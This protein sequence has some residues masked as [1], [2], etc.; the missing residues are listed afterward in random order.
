MNPASDD[1]EVQPLV[2]PSVA[3]SNGELNR[4]SPPADIMDVGLSMVV[5]NGEMKQNGDSSQTAPAIH[6]QPQELQ[7]NTAAH[8]SHIA[9]SHNKRPRE[10]DEDDD[11]DGDHP[12]KQPK[13]PK[14]KYAVLL[15]YVGKK[16]HGLQMHDQSKESGGRQLKTIESE[17][18]K[19][20]NL[21]G[22]VTDENSE[23][24]R[25]I[26]ISRSARTDKGVSACR[27]LLSVKIMKRLNEL[28]PP[29]IRVWHLT[30]VTASFDAR[31]SCEQRAYEYYM[32]SYVFSEPDPSSNFAARGGKCETNVLNS[33]GEVIGRVDETGIITYNEPATQTQSKVI[34]E[35]VEA[36]VKTDEELKL[37]RQRRAKP[38]EL[39]AFKEIMTMY[40]GSR[41]F[42]NYTIGAKFTD[43]SAVRH[44]LAIKVYDPEVI[45]S[46]DGVDVE[47]VRIRIHGQSFQLHQIRKMMAM[48]I[49]VVRTGTPV[50]VV[51]ASFGTVRVTIPK[52]PGVGLLLDELFFIR[53]NGDRQGRR[54]QAG[55]GPIDYVPHKEEIEAFKRE[56]VTPGMRQ[57]E[58]ENNTWEG[59]LKLIDRHSVWYLHYLNPQ[60]KIIPSNAEWCPGTARCGDV[61][62]SKA[63]GSDSDLEGGACDA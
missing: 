40:L 12:S 50:D 29:E 49:L 53:Y 20:L 19:A 43:A 51:K 31:K 61:A 22:C 10:Q 13:P 7:D 37:F 23:H 27:N 11:N 4:P 33:E 62:E 39:Q 47:W 17:L 63:I 15:G 16:Y 21:A 41:N 3:A 9:T 35:V 36:K 2:G 14:V 45:T 24:M 32:P 55:W 1:T 26:G 42:W 38:E 46:P 18:L 48:A 28:L 56:Q 58:A 60:G 54:K 44:M 8:K 25:K 34:Y 5:S 52:A 59:W 57:D 6:V 30:R